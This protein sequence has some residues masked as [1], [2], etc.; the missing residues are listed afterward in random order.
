VALRPDGK[1]AVNGSDDGRL[2]GATTGGKG[3]IG[4]FANDIQVNAVAFS[5]DGK[6]LVTASPTGTAQSWDTATGQPIGQPL[7]RYTGTLL[8]LAFSPDGKSLV[9]ASHA[10]IQFW[11]TATGQ[12]LGSALANSTT[13]TSLAFRTEGKILAAGNADNSVR[14]WDVATVASHGTPFMGHTGPVLS[15]AFSPDGKTLASASEDKTVMLWDVAT[16]KPLRTFEG[17]AD[18]VASVAFSPDGTR[19]L[20][21]SYDKTFKL[22]DVATGKVVATRAPPDHGSCVGGLHPTAAPRRMH[23]KCVRTNRPRVSG[24]RPLPRGAR[25]QGS[26]PPHPPRSTRS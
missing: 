23:G 18:E 4:G 26:R 22:W 6:T 13:A 12:A 20:S 2:W 17:H 10:G 14:L 15:V 19:V 7:G 8:A 5:P 24:R 11:N 9:S 25:R 1:S 21:G 16:G 3:K